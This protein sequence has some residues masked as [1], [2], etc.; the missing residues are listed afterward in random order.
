MLSVRLHTVSWDLRLQKPRSWYRGQLD[1]PLLRQPLLGAAKSAASKLHSQRLCLLF[2]C[3]RP[4]EA[5]TTIAMARGSS[6]QPRSTG[7][8]PIAGTAAIRITSMARTACPMA[9]GADHPRRSTAAAC[10]AAF[11]VTVQP[12]L[13]RTVIPTEAGQN[14]TIRSI[15]EQKAVRPAAIPVMSMLTMWIPMVTGNVTPAE[16]LFR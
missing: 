16:L 14:T 12:R 5:D 7:A 11:A 4:G 8:K 10:R 13:A 1:L 6:I 2:L 15:A 3:L 9:H